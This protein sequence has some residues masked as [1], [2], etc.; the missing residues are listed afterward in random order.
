MTDELKAVVARLRHFANGG[1]PYMLS[2]VCK[3]ADILAVC[4]AMEQRDAAVLRWVEREIMIE[5]RVH[6]VAIERGEVVIP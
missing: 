6:A 2:G 3:S 4:T 5:L 1:E